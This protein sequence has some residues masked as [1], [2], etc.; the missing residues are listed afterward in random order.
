MEYLQA[1][2][3]SIPEQYVVSKLFLLLFVKHLAVRMLTRKY[4]L[5]KARKENCTG[6]GLFLI[7]LCAAERDCSCAAF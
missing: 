1:E 6:V 4:V 3:V 2:R 5:N 7:S